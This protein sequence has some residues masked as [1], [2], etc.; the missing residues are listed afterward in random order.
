VIASDDQHVPTDDG[1]VIVSTYHRAKGLEWPVVVMSSLDR[2][3]R[4]D[5]FD[6]CPESDGAGFD[7]KAP[8]AGRWIRY[9]PWPFGA[10]EKVPLAEYAEASA[11]GKRVAAREEKERVRLLYVGFTRARDHLVLA[12]RV[13]TKN[14]TKKEPAT[15][16]AA[17]EWLDTLADAD[18]KPLLTLP[19]GGADG[20]T[21]VVRIR[22]DRGK[23]VD[24][25]ARVW[26][27]RGDAV[28]E[29]AETD[30]EARAERRWFARP[31]VAA[32]AG[33]ESGV[34]LAGYRI[35]PSN[36]QS[37]WHELAVP[38]IGEIVTLPEAMPIDA[39]VAEYNVLGDAVHAF[40]ATDVDG[41]AA[42]ER[43]ERARRILAA[44][45][46]VGVVRPDALVG[47]SDRLR[48]FVDAR[49]SGATWYREVGIDARLETSQGARRVVG[50]IDLLLET[51]EGWVIFD[52][53]TF[54]GR[55]ETAW[56]TK[57]V[58]FLPQ[59][60]AYAESLRR[61]QGKR[62]LG[63]WVHLPVGGGMVEVK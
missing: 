43:V 41:V 54:P 10:L 50:T 15:T 37:D 61:T 14:A 57:V 33:A 53:K 55:S 29:E 35:S 30:E 13:K 63:C 46:L 38:T 49:W 60:A 21:D 44:A 9:W 26:R 48:A 7:P 62:V 42:D 1:A 32:G 25:A 22:T 19:A 5:A 47:A 52:H 31:G 45:G 40:F 2:A 20:A 4:R 3:A 23:S 28:E 59:F 27:L 11:E 51:A 34:P 56:R 8:L 39:K 16:S 6:V 58:E 18:G 12:A 24:V 17:C 36:A